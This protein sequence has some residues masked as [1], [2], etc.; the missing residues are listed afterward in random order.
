MT[1]AM[2][3][4]EITA[5]ALAQVAQAACLQLRKKMGLGRCSQALPQSLTRVQT[6][7]AADGI[8]TPP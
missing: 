1:I 2:H 3:F 5:L 8:I 7:A 4:D 6:A